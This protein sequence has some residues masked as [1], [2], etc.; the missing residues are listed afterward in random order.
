M[1]EDDILIRRIDE[2]KGEEKE[3]GLIVKLLA[4]GKNVSLSL[5]EAEP[6]TTFEVHDH[7]EEELS[8][9]PQGRGIL[10]MGE[11]EYE[12]SGPTVLKIPPG[13]R[14]GLFVTGKETLLKLNA[15]SPPRTKAL[16][17]RP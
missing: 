2:I 4:T 11:K 5:L 7:E 3:P 6:G 12:I 17:K 10:T 9:I 16:K 8:Y 13:M 14:H 15:H 1:K